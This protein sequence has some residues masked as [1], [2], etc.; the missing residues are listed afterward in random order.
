MPGEDQSCVQSLGHPI[1]G[2]KK[3]IIAIMRGKG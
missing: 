3:S 1:V 2:K